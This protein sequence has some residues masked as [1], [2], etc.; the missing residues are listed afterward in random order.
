M[1]SLPRTM[2]GIRYPLLDSANLASD[3]QDMMTDIDGAMLSTA[4][5]AAAVDDVDGFRVTGGSCTAASGVSATMSF[6]I[7]SYDL[8][9][10]VW[11]FGSPTLFALPPAYWLITVRASCTVVGNT[12][13]AAIQAVYNGR[14]YPTQVTNILQTV[15]QLQ[16]TFMIHAVPTGGNM[17]IAGTA[18]GTGGGNFTISQGIVQ[19]HRLRVG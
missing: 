18:W 10:P 19:A 8:T 3:I 12:D 1:T 4:N 2:L 14:R 7:D 15:T 5:R 16:S 17:T 13:H 6:L 11:V 9:P